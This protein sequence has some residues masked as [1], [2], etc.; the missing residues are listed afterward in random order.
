MCVCVF[1]LSVMLLTSVGS[2]AIGGCAAV[3][4]RGRK[5][6]DINTARW[7]YKIGSTGHWQPELIV[8]ERLIAP[9]YGL[10]GKFGRDERITASRGW[11]S[12]SWD[13]I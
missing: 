6:L 7:N 10:V 8:Y 9:P 3:T 1:D 4:S 2:T 5:S 12:D 11:I 13:K